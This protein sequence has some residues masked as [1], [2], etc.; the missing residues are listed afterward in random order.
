MYFNPKNQRLIQVEV[1]LLYG[2]PTVPPL[3]IDPGGL[4]ESKCQEQHELCL[5]L[6]LHICSTL[7]IHSVNC[8]D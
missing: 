4:Q 3:R 8:F 5:S 2:Y 6:M 1:P 7:S